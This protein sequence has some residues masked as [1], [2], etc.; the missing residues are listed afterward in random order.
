MSADRARSL[1][2]LLDNLSEPVL[3]VGG[4]GEILAAN[5]AAERT[6]GRELSGVA[7][8]FGGDLFEC[9]FARLPGGCGKTAHCAACTIRQ[10]VNEV[11]ATGH[12]VVDR[13]AWIEREGPDGVH[14]RVDLVVSAEKLRDMVLL[15]IDRMD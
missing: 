3:C 12:T 7:G 15:R 11:A 8:T 9:R 6:L 4:R 10:T 14:G 13:R 1:R 5:A 2:D